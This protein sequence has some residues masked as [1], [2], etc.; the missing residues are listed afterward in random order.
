MLFVEILL[1]AKK[2]SSVHWNSE[3]DS[4]L[5]KLCE[6]KTFNLLRWNNKSILRSAYITGIIYKKFSSFFFVFGS[7]QVLGWTQR[8]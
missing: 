3:K 7:A 1:S 2:K 4:V 8:S 6:A 5:G